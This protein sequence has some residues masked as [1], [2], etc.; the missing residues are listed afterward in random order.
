MTKRNA[1]IILP[2]ELL[3]FKRIMESGRISDDPL[4]PEFVK[5]VNLYETLV[6]KHEAVS[7]ENERFRI[8]LSE[9]SRSLELASRIDPMTGLANRRDIMEKIDREASR[10]YRHQGTFSI[11]LADIDD[12]SKI[13]DTYGFN[14]GDEVLV[15]VATVFRG[16][17]RGEDICARWGGE[18]FL[19][20][21]PETGVEGALAA[22]QKIHESISMTEFRANKQGIRTTVSLGLCEFN[23]EQSVL[24]CINKAND[25]L[26][27]AKRSG[28]NR[29]FVAAR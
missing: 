12:F 10:V 1:S 22:A 2:E 28:K 7:R 23:P 8:Q 26:Q 19:F 13:N 29:Y 9:M 24:D 18:E 14:A 6:H 3:E 15:E 20:L 17:V 25:A 27:Q 21:L 16:C 5:L 4:F 11:I